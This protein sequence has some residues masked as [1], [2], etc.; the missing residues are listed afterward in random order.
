MRKY[1]EFINESLNPYAGL[2]EMNS[3]DVSKLKEELDN[4][5][6]SYSYTN[7]FLIVETGTKLHDVYQLILNNNGKKTYDM[8]TEGVILRTPAFTIPDGAFM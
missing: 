8:N 7:N 5:D 6:I 2:Y 4:I 1:V 3:E